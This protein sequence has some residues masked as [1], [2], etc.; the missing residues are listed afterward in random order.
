MSTLKEKL[1]ALKN[2]KS[3]KKSEAESKIETDD[4]WKEPPQMD[5]FDKQEIS[6]DEA[7]KEAF[8]IVLPKKKP[9]RPKGRSSFKV[10]FNLT[11]ESLKIMDALRGENGRSVYLQSLLKEAALTFAQKSSQRDKLTKTLKAWKSSKAD[12]SIVFSLF[13]ILGI[14]NRE[15]FRAFYGTDLSKELDNLWEDF[16][17]SSLKKK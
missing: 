1:K 9:G 13:S 8:T 15:D 10:T 14:R 6:Y 3:L 2:E 17:F 4:Q 5:L 7:F 11:A 16:F 12:S